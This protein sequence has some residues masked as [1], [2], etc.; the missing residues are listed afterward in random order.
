MES[1]NSE[2]AINNDM[3]GEEISNVLFCSCVSDEMLI[4]VCL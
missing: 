2:L 4:L 1:E 3:I